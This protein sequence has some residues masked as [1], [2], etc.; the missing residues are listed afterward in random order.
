MPL[1]LI[2]EKK[3]C[4]LIQLLQLLISY[5]EDYV[6]RTHPEQSGNESFVKCPKTLV[7][8]CLNKTIGGTGVDVRWQEASA[9]L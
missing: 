7:F 4:C 9:F 6:P 5:E 1:V 3:K 8:E 2:L